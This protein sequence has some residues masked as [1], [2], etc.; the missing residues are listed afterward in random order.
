MLSSSDDRGRSE[1]IAAR[2]PPWVLRQIEILC[3]DPDTPFDTRA[4]FVRAAIAHFLTNSDYHVSIP[5]QSLLKLSSHKTWEMDVHRKIDQI[6]SD[7]ERNL[8]LYH[9][10]GGDQQAHEMIESHLAEILKEPDSFWR[11]HF[12]EK[13]FSSPIIR[14]VIDDD[15]I[16]ENTRIA[17]NAWHELQDM[18]TQATGG[19][20]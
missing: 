4:D 10:L 19:D 3:L 16:G 18:E 12:I 14:E 6:I 13:L 17:L 20:Y 1:T 5:F 15:N 2:V 8:L 11:H 9:R 7:L